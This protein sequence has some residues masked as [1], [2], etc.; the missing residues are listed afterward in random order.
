MNNENL[1]SFRLTAI[2]RTCIR[3]SHPKATVPVFWGLS[4]ISILLIF[5]FLGS[6]VLISSTLIQ[7]KDQ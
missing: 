2:D 1:L 3:P 5:Y 4:R 6:L 7:P